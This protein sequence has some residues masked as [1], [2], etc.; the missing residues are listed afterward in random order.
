MFSR[1]GAR[2]IQCLERHTL[3]FFI[4][5]TAIVGFVYWFAGPYSFVQRGDTIDWFVPRC[6]AV[7]EQIRAGETSRWI[8]QLTMGVD[9]YALDVHPW[10]IGTLI[11]VFLSPLWGYMAITL[12][13]YFVGGWS[14]YHLLYRRMGMS[15]VASVIGALLFMLYLQLNQPIFCIALAIAP[16]ALYWIDVIM[17]SSRRMMVMTAIPLGF[18]VAFF[19][20]AVLSLPYVLGAIIIFTILRYRARPKALMVLLLFIVAAFGFYFDQLFA[21][22]DLMRM[23]YRSSSAPVFVASRYVKQVIEYLNFYA[24]PLLFGGALGIL[25]LRSH[26]ADVRKKYSIIGESF[27]VVAL[28]VVVAQ[29]EPHRFFGGVSFVGKLSAFPLER[30][31][32]VLPLFVS[33]IVA[34]AID[35]LREA[36]LVYYDTVFSL[37]RIGVISMV[38]FL[39]VVYMSSTADNLYLWLMGRSSFAYLRHP[40]L[41]LLSEEARAGRMPFRVMDVGSGKYGWSSAFI[42]LN[43]LEYSGGGVNVPTERQRVWWGNIDRTRSIIFKIIF[44]FHGNDG[45]HTRELEKMYATDLDSAVNVTLLG[46]ANVKFVVNTEYSRHR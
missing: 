10:Y 35:V 30:F 2:I 20:N 40:A 26:R 21:I 45:Q 16:A 14:L 23:S 5:A 33:M 15:T 13:S 44:Q 43:G 34:G 41:H 9:R 17:A 38:I 12:F 4:I 32:F 1:L 28:I 31:T 6:V 8:P 19:G 25:L 37:R 24:V 18:L 27:I 46:L 3:V 42:T 29:L 36:R 7:A 22:A 39:G 11:F